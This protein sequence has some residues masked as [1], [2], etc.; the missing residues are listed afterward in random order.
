MKCLIYFILFPLGVLLTSC[1][2]KSNEF[3]LTNEYA[4]AKI[5]KNYNS[6][7]TH[8]VF[9][10]DTIQ[11]IKNKI[12]QIEFIEVSKFSDSLSIRYLTKN[13][14]AYHHFYKSKH[15]D[16]SSH[17]Y[18]TY[19]VFDKK[20]KLGNNDYEN[21][22]SVLEY[23]LIKNKKES[24]LGGYILGDTTNTKIHNFQ[25]GQKFSLGKR[26]YTDKF[27]ALYDFDSSNS[28]YSMRIVNYLL[29]NF[30]SEKFI[31]LWEQDLSS[32]KSIYNKSFKSVESD[33]QDALANNTKE[34]DSN[35]LR[36]YHQVCN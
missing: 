31:K 20:E 13:K 16:A 6:E 28:S 19:I 17:F 9:V 35:W 4:V 26:V 25:E 5:K 36:Y 1:D 3:N 7:I 12:N 21:M 15:V 27:T 14:E 2:Q 29:R 22:L 18:T 30:T 11:Q 23:D 33:Y 24:Y 34:K 32:F 10:K 8:E